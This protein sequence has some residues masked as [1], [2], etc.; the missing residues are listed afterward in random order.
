MINL[1]VPVE[2]GSQ[3]PT[4]R[5]D[6]E[7]WIHFGASV[8]CALSVLTKTQFRRQ[9]GLHALEIQPETCCLGDGD[10]NKRRHF[11]WTAAMGRT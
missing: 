8:R 4:L 7:G 11:A 1:N 2:A 5:I 3:I 10:L 6:Q 9:S